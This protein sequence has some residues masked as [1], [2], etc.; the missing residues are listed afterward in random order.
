MKKYLK[1]PFIVLV[2]F[3]AFSCNNSK[4]SKTVTQ[5]GEINRV[6]P[7]DFNSK[8]DDNILID[9]RTPREF[10][11]GHLEGA[12][13]VNYFDKAFLTQMAK[14]DKS[15]AIFIYCRSGSRTSSASKKLANAGFTLIYD[16]HG[17]ISNW[18]KN[19]F[20]IVK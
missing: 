19:K 15:K 17:G 3:I 20:K 7:Q 16:L 18:H 14:Y 13:N 4:P 1:L 10:E 9:I 2:T 6:T 11:Q 5:N 8:L 12:V